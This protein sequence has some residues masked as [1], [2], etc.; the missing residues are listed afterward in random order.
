MST[1]CKKCLQNG[2]SELE[3]G[4]N[5]ALELRVCLELTYHSP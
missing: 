3:L 4:K 1:N 5:K 2:H